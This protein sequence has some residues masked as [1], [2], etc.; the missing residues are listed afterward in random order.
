MQEYLKDIG[1]K[2]VI[3][4][5]IPWDDWVENY[6][7]NSDGHKNLAYSFGGWG[8][9][10]NDPINMIEPLYGTNANSNCFILNN[11]TWNDKLIATYSAVGDTRRDLFYEIQE[12]FCKIHVPSF[13]L[14]QR[15]DSLFFNREYLD[16][17]SVGDLLNIF[18]G[19]YWFHCK[20]TPPPPIP[21]PPDPLAPPIGIIGAVV[22]GITILPVVY[23]IISRKVRKIH[24]F[25]M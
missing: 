5:A 13:Y 1:I 25:S 20:F 15:G 4:D 18:G 17:D 6:L 7:E 11:D 22:G 23:V 10:Y 2:L 19:L 14:L 16:E 3:L 24:S 12:D 21:A 8:P 9:D